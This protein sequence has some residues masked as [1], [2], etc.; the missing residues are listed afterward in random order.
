[1]VLRAIPSA[2][3]IPSKVIYNLG[4]SQPKLSYWI[5]IGLVSPSIRKGKKGDSITSTA[6]WSF[7]DLLK[8]KT[9][10]HLREKRLSLQR[11]RKVVEWLEDNDCSIDSTELVTDGNNVFARLDGS[12]IEILEKTGQYLILDWS[13]IV[14]LCKRIFDDNFVNIDQNP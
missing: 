3:G 12:V 6:L 1:M 13:N 10:W 14:S 11:M 8:I 7:S 9:I 5:K 4:I 2:R